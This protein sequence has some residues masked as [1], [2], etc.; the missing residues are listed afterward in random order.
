MDE[1]HTANT[2]IVDYLFEILNSSQGVP[3]TELP[4]KFELGFQKLIP[5]LRCYAANG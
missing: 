1:K 5:V 2:G 4:S 3:A